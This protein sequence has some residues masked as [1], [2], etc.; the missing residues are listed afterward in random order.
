M[1]R[2]VVLTGG[3]GSGKSE[4]AINLA[5][6]LAAR[7]Q[8]A[9]VDLDIANP[10]FRSRE[11]RHFLAEQGIKPVVPREE[12]LDADLPILSPGVRSLLL[13]SAWTV[14][15]DVG[16]DEIGAIA[17][18]GFQAVFQA[19]EHQMLM[20][21][22]PF[23]PFTRD[24]E[25]IEFMCR[26]IERASRLKMQGLI[27]NPNLGQVT[28]LEHVLSGHQIVAQAARKL[29]LPVVGLG[30]LA[31]RLE[32]WTEQPGATAEQHGAGTEQMGATVT[33]QLP[34]STEQQE[35]LADQPGVCADWPADAPAALTD[36]QPTVVLDQLGTLVEQLTAIQEA[37]IPLLPIRIHL[38]PDW[39]FKQQKTN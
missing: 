34:A 36:N 16:G 32:E 31:E 25:S 3:F 19:I 14:V 4:I 17:L 30:V 24:V 9:L 22:N 39:L 21:V 1:Q 35:A 27:S 5:L 23:R 12:W 8:T 38:S 29:D 28:Q 20:V 7:K 2:V 37:G 15:L 18:G 33:N 11:A 26:E 10:Y 13:D 6:D